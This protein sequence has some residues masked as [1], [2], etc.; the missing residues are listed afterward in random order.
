MKLRSA[1]LLLIAILLLMLS[2][3]RPT[4]TLVDGQYLLDNIV[5]KNKIKTIDNEKL[6]PF[7][8]QKPNSRLLGIVRNRLFFYNLAYNS[9]HPKRWAW[10]KNSS[11]PPVILDSMLTEK[12]RKQ[13]ELFVHNKGYFDSSVS[14]SIAITGKKKVCIYYSITSSVPYT[15]RDISYSISDPQIAQIVVRNTK[16]LS[17]LKSGN[18][19]DVDVLQ[20]E[21]DRIT[22]DLR[23]KGFYYFLKEYIY[24]QV[25]SSMGNHQIDIILGIKNKEIA[26]GESRHERYYLNNIYIQTDYNFRNNI[27]NDTVVFNDYHFTNQKPLKYK[28]KA[29]TQHIFYKKEDIF[30]IDNLTLT[31]NRLSNLNVFKSV[32]I[33]FEDAPS[34]SIGNKQLDCFIELTAAPTN[35]FAVEMEGTHNTT[36]G[37]GVAG[38]FVYKNKNLFRGAEIFEFKMK[39]AMQIQKTFSDSTVETNKFLSIFNTLEVGPEVTIS[40]PRF[41][42][43][44]GSEKISKLYNPKTVFT[45]SATL[46]KRDD[47]TRK[48]GNI[49]L[50]YNWKESEFKTHSI[51]IPNISYIRIDPN[52]S[53]LQN[54]DIENNILL[55]SQFSD[56]FITGA[57]YSFVYNNQRLNKLQNFVYFKGNLELAGNLM[58]LASIIAGSKANSYGQYNLLGIAYAQYVIPD[59]EF[60]YY[61]IFSP[62][63]SLVYRIALGLGVPYENSYALPFVKSFSAGGPNDIRAWKAYS[64]GPGGFH[65]DEQ[66]TQVGDVKMEANIEGR[67]DI[68]KY[69]EGALFID[70]GNVWLMREDTL[71]PGGNFSLKDS[72]LFI[73]QIAIGA[74]I[75]LRF[76]FSFFI[77]RLDAGIP[78]RT[79]YFPYGQKWIWYAINNPGDYGEGEGGVWKN[80]VL[81]RINFNLG[82]GYPF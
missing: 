41:L 82:I 11:E 16:D 57:K 77:F 36:N 70:A 69:L 19:Y 72:T 46:Q 30:R 74:G 17:L 18:I 52:S 12:S 54:N 9:K 2:S 40:F 39:G 59:I 1:Y 20:L 6:V 34:D 13:L 3:C 68:Y 45:A 21:R 78:I 15:I 48:M 66:R 33:R 14:D 62:Y 71:R 5:F 27:V 37:N 25:D 49:S 32:N 75:G 51:T 43:P 55:K 42:I 8:K 53:I 65:S 50:T 60:K 31:Y 64:L 81:D 23:N 10:L 26:T 22:K 7:L 35:S 29:I 58:R 28:A 47:Y 63:N 44:W 38:S 73:N 61:K 80:E 76:D 67:F 4:K 79:P 24:F 56:Q